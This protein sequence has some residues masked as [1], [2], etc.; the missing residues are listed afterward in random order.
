MGRG[1]GVG[2][3]TDG[4]EAGRGSGRHLSIVGGERAER[5]QP[6]PAP[7]LAP[8]RVLG[9]GFR[10]GAERLVVRGVSYG[11][12]RPNRA[13]DLF[14]EPEQ[15]ARDFAAMAASAI[16]SVRVYTAP[17]RWL[18]DLAAEHGLRVLVG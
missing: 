12:F 17:P 18:L 3:G 2:G 4:T 5:A 7:P 16:N 14:P 10:T 15:V 1:T 8:V 6:R 11:T 13:G 9:R